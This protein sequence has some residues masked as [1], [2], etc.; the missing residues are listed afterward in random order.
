MKILPK[1]Q[2]SVQKN[3]NYSFVIPRIPL[4]GIPDDT[5]IG[6]DKEKFYF[7][8]NLELS[9]PLGEGWL[10]KN[11]RPMKDGTPTYGHWK[12]CTLGHHTMIV[13]VWE[14]TSSCSIEFNPAHS[15]Y[16]NNELLL[17]PEAN[18]SMMKVAIE[19]TGLVP[20]FAVIDSMGT[21]TWPENWHEYLGVSFVEL[22]R[23]L[24]VEPEHKHALQGALSALVPPRGYTR[25]IQSRR[26]SYS[27]YYKTGSVGR[28]KIYDKTVQMRDEGMQQAAE[29]DAHIF[30]YETTLKSK[31]LK[32]YGLRNPMNFNDQ[33]VWEVLTE[34]FN[35]CRWEVR[36][37][38]RNDLITKL[39]DAP[40]AKAERLLGFNQMVSLGLDK[41]L[42]YGARRDRM[43]LAKSF[44]VTPGTAFEFH[45][46][47]SLR[48]DLFSGKLVSESPS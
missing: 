21:I 10:P 46:S 4:N 11:G 7:P 17:P 8:V 42:A 5:H 38:S 16:G 13:N 9:L 27:L 47:E 41:T 1:E 26:D 30:R 34:R 22:A 23:N 45:A 32:K 36:L 40:Y 6:I 18:L 43:G 24:F 39:S 25:D 19:A 14:T 31:R 35:V 33:I 37:P 2:A 20:G 12:E 28:D 29:T 3:D 44:G 48:F 15:L